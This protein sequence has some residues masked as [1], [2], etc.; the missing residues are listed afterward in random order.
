MDSYFRLGTSNFAFLT[1]VNSNRHEEKET[2]A[3]QQ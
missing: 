1:S 2:E 3:E